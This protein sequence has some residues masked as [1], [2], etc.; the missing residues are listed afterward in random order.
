MLN[1]ETAAARTSS[2][3][4]RFPQD[5]F[6]GSVS[7]ATKTTQTV[8]ITQIALQNTPLINFKSNQFQT[9]QK[10]S[11][12]ISKTERCFTFKLVL[13]TLSC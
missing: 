8:I 9:N 7:A 1:A 4:Q 11:Q 3:S 5:I 6:G 12:T 10:P 13:Q 2:T